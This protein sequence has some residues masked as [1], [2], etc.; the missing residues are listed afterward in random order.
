MT[1]VNAMKR[2]GLKLFVLLMIVLLSVIG[3]AGA[4]TYEQC[5]YGCGGS[6][7]LHDKKI[8]DKCYR[9]KD[10]PLGQGCELVYM[11]D[12]TNPR[13]H[14]IGCIANAHG[15]DPGSPA[16][17]IANISCTYNNNWF[18]VT[19]NNEVVQMCDNC[20]TFTGDG[21]F[22]GGDVTEK[23]SPGNDVEHDG[24]T[25]VN[26]W[27]CSN[28]GDVYMVAE[29]CAE[30]D[31][32]GVY[33]LH[34][35]RICNKCHSVKAGET[36]KLCYKYSK[37]TSTHDITCLEH[38]DEGFLQ[39]AK[40]T[41]GKGYYRDF[42]GAKEK[43]CDLCHNND[44]QHLD[45]TITAGDS[46][47]V[48]TLPDGTHLV[49]SLKC[50]TCEDIFTA[51]A[52]ECKENAAHEV[53][54]CEVCYLDDD[55]RVHNPAATTPEDCEV[56]SEII[57]EQTP[58]EPVC[59]HTTL[60]N[61]YFTWLDAKQHRE[62]SQCK[63]C[64]EAMEITS[65]HS[66]NASWH[67]GTVCL[68]CRTDANGVKHNWSNGECT[69]CPKPIPDGLNP[70]DGWYYEGG[71]KSDFTG[72]AEYNGS[73]FYIL[74]G[75]WQRNAN[76]LTLIIDEFWFLA[77]GQVQEHH[78][79]ALYDGEWFYL[80]GGK[81]DTTASGLFKYDGEWFLVAAGRLVSE[82]KGLAQLPNGDWYY[83]ADG[84]MVQ[85]YSGVVQWAGDLFEVANGKMLRWIGPGNRDY[86]GILNGWY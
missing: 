41:Y 69:V 42:N 3:M 76:G 25:F 44:G 77:G 28:C 84:R 7:K 16:V 70:D 39:V 61:R 71:E 10:L 65:S 75:E 2:Y 13:V 33:K 60:I 12:A 63:D 56:C 22:S 35:G 80:D 4:G 59:K 34:D 43:V 23:E 19:A 8:C 64:G 37:T 86:H 15:G 40:C 46:N 1:E 57:A 53:P 78:G 29:R 5:E 68:Y 58:E 47:T 36:C 24:K 49:N 54:I 48:D 21:A 45:G 18:K 66:A 9:P 31:C 55:G 32:D 52:H 83:I 20:H 38:P 79:F 72:L 62:S 85:E 27:E 67:N 30:P 81:L 14:S 11:Y 73:L 74:N 6:Y 51:L 26:R 50:T 82:R 17:V